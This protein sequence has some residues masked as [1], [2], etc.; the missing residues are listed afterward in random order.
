MT[1]IVCNQEQTSPRPSAPTLSPPVY[2]VGIKPDESPGDPA[3][4]VLA[5]H[6]PAGE[7]YSWA[8]SGD[9]TP[10]WEKQVN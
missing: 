10:Q 6:Q 8:D 9:F 2:S 3:A 4:G 1:A 7:A 5:A